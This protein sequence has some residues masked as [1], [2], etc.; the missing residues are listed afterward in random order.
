M[1]TAVDHLKGTNKYKCEKYVCQFLHATKSL[2]L[3]RCKKLVNADKQFTVHEAPLVLTIHLKRFS[4]MG[5]KIGHP[6]RYEERVTLEPLMS[7]GRFG[8]SYSLYGVISH[9]GGGPNSGHYY[10]HVK[11][12]TGQWYEMNDESVTRQSGAPTGMKN[13]YMLFYVRDKGQA[14]EAALNAPSTSPMRIP[15]TGIVANM[16]KRRIVESDDEDGPSPAKRK[17]FI[18]P[19][20]PTDPSTS[21]PSKGT[22]PKADPQAELLKKKIAA[23]TSQKAKGALQSLVDYADDSDEDDD[24]VGEKVSTKDAKKDGTPPPSPSVAPPPLPSDPVPEVTASSSTPAAPSP[25]HAAS[26]PAAS[27]IPP[28]SFYGTPAPKAKDKK[29]KSPDDEGGDDS[30][31]LAEY[32]RTPLPKPRPS[33]MAR[34][35][36]ANPFDRLKGSNNLQQRR[37]KGPLVRYGRRKKFMF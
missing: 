4:P 21:S 11:S 24:D 13:A 2:I 29:R 35:S 18:G 25:E 31:S 3:P 17:A 9:A 10:A 34:F 36:P 16:K 1:F 7:E 8:P 6:V 27:T 30:A 12:A 33:P 37:D 5:R 19:L 23:A 22:T 20:L 15:K 28:S 14:L 26:S 32:A